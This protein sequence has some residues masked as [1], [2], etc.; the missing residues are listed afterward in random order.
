MELL[1]LQY[2][3][4]VAE[5]EHMT[6]AA[7]EL[8][9]AQ[10]ALSKT[11]S[12]LEE[13]VG[14]PLFDRKGRQIRLNAYGKAFLR[15]VETALQALEDGQKE[16]EDM[17]GL[18]RGRVYVATTTHK[19]FSDAI[20]DF[21]ARRP[22]ARLH[23]SQASEAEKTEKLRRG[24]LDL[25]ITFPPIQL[26]D[27]EG[28][29]FLTERIMLAVPLGHPFAGRGSIRLAEAA[30]EPFICIKPENPFREMTDEFC[31][32]AGFAPNVVCEVDEHSAVG[33]FLSTG[34]GIAFLPE[35]LLEK[36]D[37]PFHVLEIEEPECLRTYQ[38]A[39]AKNRYLS[40]AAKEF[41]DFIV[42]RFASYPNIRA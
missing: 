40:A 8:H 7:E 37:A 24:E 10:P 41:R 35:T 28:A 15:K 4:K 5:L 21:I 20:G 13:D 12:R 22:G 32:Q 6:K 34:I 23:I 25:C 42:Q 36:F 29:A 3:R 18:E 33:H 17:A 39:W 30:A 19:C 9:I 14:V 1:Q 38:I 11:I 2:F 31:R 16:V 26:P 27:I